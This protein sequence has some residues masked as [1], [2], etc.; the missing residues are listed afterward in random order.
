VATVLI[1]G[2]S[3]GIGR[4]TALRFAR[5]GYG[6]VLAARQP[7]RLEALAAQIRQQGGSALAVPTDICDREAAGAL[8][9]RALAHAGQVDVLVNNAGICLMG[10]AA[11]TSYQDWQ[12]LF[13]TNFWGY[14][15]TIQALLPHWLERGSGILVNVGSIG[16][17]MPL[18]NMAAY[19]ASKYAVTGLTEALRL[20]LEPQGIRVCSV[21]PSVTR[22]AF[23][24]RAAFRGQ[25]SQAIECQRQQTDSALNSPMASDPDAVARAIWQAVRDRRPETVVGSGALAAAL[26]RWAPGLAQWLLQRAPSR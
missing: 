4:A 22:S 11:S 3:Q 8:I 25:D 15:H 18:P 6:V 2:A 9:E 10:P 24:E 19:T 1:T 7:E 13:D 21:H 23:R 20:E 26:Y 12:Q 14:L 17:K 16:G 5:H